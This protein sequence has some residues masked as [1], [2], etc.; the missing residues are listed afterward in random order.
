MV[1]T[2]VWRS[3]GDWAVRAE[4]QEGLGPSKTHRIVGLH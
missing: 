2:V 4:V 3:V 1:L